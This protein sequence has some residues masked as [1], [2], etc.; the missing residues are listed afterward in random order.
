MYAR[1]WFVVVTGCFASFGAR[2]AEQGPDA[3]A[4]P[5]ASAYPRV[6]HRA[7]EV[8]VQTLGDDGAVL[9]SCRASAPQTPAAAPVGRATAPDAGV[10]RT[11]GL[12]ADLAVQGTMGFVGNAHGTVVLPGF[13]AFA[14]FGA[15]LG[16]PVAWGLLGS[17]MLVTDLPNMIVTGALTPAVHFG[18]HGHFSL[19]LG[20]SYGY[21]AGSK[22][23][24]EGFMLAALA[25]GAIPIAEGFG[26]HLQAAFF[27]D[28]GGLVMGL[29]AGLGWSA[30]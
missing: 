3:G 14:S 18:E 9:E 2:A 25:H 29:S 10:P 26:A 11:T 19:G 5:S 8:C 4:Q 21:G 20:P 30:W 6:V 23:S 24:G 1:A 22:G 16:T 13:T 27:I 15:R 28:G 17:F 12:V 7:G